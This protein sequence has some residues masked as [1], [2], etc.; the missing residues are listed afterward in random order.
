MFADC[1]A[2]HATWV[3]TVINLDWPSKPSTEIADDTKRVTAQKNDLLAILDRAKTLGLNA[4]IF[5]VSPTADAFYQ[6]SILP[7]SSYLTG[8]LGKNPGF[9]P[10]K[11][12]I[13]EAH[14]RDI[15]VHAWIN[16]YRVSMNTNPETKEALENSSPDSPASVYKIHPEWIGVAA[17]RYVLDPGIPEVRDWVADV[18]GEVVQK[19]DV[20]GIQ[21]D[22]YFYNETPDSKLDDDK[23]FARYGTS[24]KDKADW[25]RYNTYMLVKEVFDRVKKIKPDV[26]FG[27]SP[28]GVWRN[29]QDDPLGSDT[30]AGATNYDTAFADTR[31]W[32][33]E[34]M[35]DYI[36]PQVYWPLERK[37]VPYGTIVKWWAQT[38]QETPVD[39]YIGMALYKAGQAT[40]QEPQWG[41][42]GG[43][44]EIKHQLELNE[45][46]P[47]V[48][49]SI[50]FR[51]AF[52][53]DPKLTKVT[54]YLKEQWG[55]CS[56]RKG[57][58]SE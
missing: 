30:H 52:L 28:G 5:Q 55:R 43:L 2:L 20:D 54:D 49:G 16:P 36:A 48:K 47:E 1:N 12:V 19:Y 6:S 38:V 40:P 45:S 8:T 3:S 53:S 56:P 7:W 21:F 57:A 13:E 27:I 24:F 29:K 44:T 14:K 46:V 34:G 50:L 9:D 51:E 39:L 17:K 35:I 11:F 23:T 58:P 22:D 37:I 4:I 10:L 32:V 18:V 41:E 26:R 15:K 31:R 33:K 25:R 42:D